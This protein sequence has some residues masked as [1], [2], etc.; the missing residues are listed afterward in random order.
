MSND[1][2]LQDKD[3]QRKLNQLT[4]ITNELA[5]EARRRHGSSGGI[6][7][8]AHGIFYFMSGDDMDNVEF[9]SDNIAKMDCG[10]W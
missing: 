9:S 8:E 1:K 2:E 7:Y 5:E 4:K 6:Y 3:I 10:G